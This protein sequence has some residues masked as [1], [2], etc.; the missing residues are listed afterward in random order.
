MAREQHVRFLAPFSAA[1]I[2]FFEY[3]GGFGLFVGRVLRSLADFRTYSG[4]LTDQMLRIGVRSLPIVLVISAFAGMVTAVQGAYQLRMGY[5]P[6]YAIATAVVE[7]VL[8]E[9]APVLTALVLSGRVGA[10]IAAELGTMKVTE[11]ID[12][13]ESLAFDPV[14]YLVVPRVLAGLIAF[15]VLTIF[16]AFTG[17]LAGALISVLTVHLSPFDFL[18]G[19]RMFFVPWDAFYGQIKAVCFGLTITLVACH[20]GFSAKGGAEGVGL[21]TTRAVV[22][23]CLLILVLDYF[24]ALTLL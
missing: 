22:V 24:L 18:H 4:N 14:S 9:L 2:A 15:P 21:A 7:S 23:S 11:Q 12:A 13:L 16:S 10:N 19:A 17:I 1:P 6:D 8:L 3:L 5:I 20:E